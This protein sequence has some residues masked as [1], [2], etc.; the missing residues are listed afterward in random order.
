MEDLKLLMQMEEHL[1]SKKSS[2]D[3]LWQVIAEHFYPERANFTYTRY[4]GEEFA[5]NLMTGYPVLARRD[6]GDAFSSMLRRQE[7][8]FQI[9]LGRE[10]QETTEV[11]Q[12]LEWAAGLQRRAMYDRQACFVRATKEGDHDFAAFGQAVISVEVDRTQ[13]R[14]LYRNWHLKD[15]AWSENVAG[16]I[17]TFFLRWKP[18]A[19]DLINKFKDVHEK[20][21][22]CMEKEPFKEINCVHCLVPGEKRKYR[23][24]YYD[25]DNKHVMEDV[26][27]DF[28]RYVIPRWSTVS[29]SQYAYSPAVVVALPDAR[30][31][32]AVTLT[33]LE[34]GEKYVN[35]PLLATHEALRSDV[36]LMAGGLTWIDA[37]YDERLGEAVRPLVQDKGAFPAGF[38]IR[39]DIKESIGSA[40]YLSKLTLPPV[41]EMTAYEVSQR[42]QEYIRQALPLFQPM[43]AEYNGGLCDRT[44]ELL[45]MHNA[46]GEIPQALRGADVQ[47]QF[48]SPLH[49]AEDREKAVRFEEMVNTIGMAAGVD[50][51]TAKHV[52]IHEAFRDAIS[53]L[54]APAD[55]IVS[56]EAAR[57]M[58]ANAKNEQEEALA[59]QQMAQ[60]AG[61][62][63]G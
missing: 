62:V 3:S 49:H 6:L 57:Q 9:G 35:P 41:G 33:L 12:W 24:V 15:C 20:V 37:A 17:D 56:E 55:W 32:Q 39:D 13:A 38:N 5:D 53:G 8:W 59:M 34:A 61:A 58:I 43:E 31:I 14:L 63:S 44:F 45:M 52:D 27:L 36:N 23:S 40:F 7:N 21:R 47:F 4:L 16:Q 26:E 30:L 54:G 29:Q 51:T 46:F 19:R 2:L 10:D 22:Q 1:F 28:F 42:I 60:V 25:K 18:T 11:K 50:P 48:D